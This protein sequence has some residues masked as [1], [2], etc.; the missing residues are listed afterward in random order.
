[1][2]VKGFHFEENSETAVMLD[3]GC[4]LDIFVQVYTLRNRSVK[5]KLINICYQ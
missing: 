1:M 3:V 4:C 2:L 5:M